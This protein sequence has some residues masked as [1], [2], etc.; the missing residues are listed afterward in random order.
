L[1]NIYWLAAYPKSG[2]TWFRAFLESLSTGGNAVDINNLKVVSH[3]S[4]RV[5]FDR[6]L[7]IDSAYLTVDEITSAR[8]RL[9]E[10]EAMQ[11]HAPLFRKTH[12]AWITTLTG[13]PLFPPAVTLGAILIVRDPR[14][15][16]VSLAHQMTNTVDYA[17]ERL[18][19]PSGMMDMA[20]QRVNHQLPQKLS[21]WSLHTESWLSAPIKLHLLKYEDMLGDPLASFGAAASFLGFDAAPEK[22][23]QA[24]DAVRFDRLRSA[25]EKSSYLGRQPGMDRFFRRGV[26]GGWRDSLTPA[27]VAC[28]E[29]D[30]GPMMRRLGYL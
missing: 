14:D 11:A 15:V 9:F 12:D 20:V 1:K 3:T 26:A 30:H 16:A 4:S 6:V 8:P 2:S 23:A 17:I 28:I 27:Q 10:I 24:V 21:S 29:A 25:E 18:G 13:G 7:D 5:F 19:N 22:I